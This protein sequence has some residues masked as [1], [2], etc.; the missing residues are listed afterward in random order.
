MCSGLSEGSVLMSS[1]ELNLSCLEIDYPE[2]FS[3]QNWY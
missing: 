2:N 3:L 1:F